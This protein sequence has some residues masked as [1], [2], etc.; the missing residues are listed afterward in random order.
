MLQPFITMSIPYFLVIAAQIGFIIHAARTGR[1]YYW[2]MIILFI[3][4]MGVVA[5]VIVELLPSAARAPTTSRAMDKAKRLVDPEGDY[6]ALADKLD[7]TPTIENRKA[8]AQE[9]LKL[10]KLEEAEALYRGSLVGV[11]ATDPDLMLGVAQV[12]FA[13]NDP[14]ACLETLAAIRAANPGFQN[15]D[16]HM[17]F[18]RSHEALAM[19]DEALNEYE[20]LSHYFGGEEPRIRR[21]LLLKKIGAADSARQAFAEVKRSVERA[22]SFYRRNQREWYRV[23]QQNLKG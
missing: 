7:L 23:A 8:L 10:G 6:R 3:P 13:Q 1:P 5:Y 19:N 11:H 4:V 9:C 20:A 2:L 12:Q 16:A 18:A 17:L 21:A 15:A 22:P 14:A